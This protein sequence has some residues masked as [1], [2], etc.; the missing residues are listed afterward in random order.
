M[1]PTGAPTSTASCS[2]GRF[3]LTDFAD[4][5]PPYGQFRRTLSQHRGAARDQL[6]PSHR[7]PAPASYA[8]T[9]G[10]TF[11]PQLAAPRRRRDEAERAGPTSTAPALTTIYVYLVSLMRCPTALRIIHRS[12]PPTA[13]PPGPSVPQRRNSPVDR[14]PD[15][16]T[17]HPDM[18]LSASHAL[19]S[20]ISGVYSTPHR[21]SRFLLGGIPCFCS[22]RQTAE[23][24][25]ALRVLYVSVAGILMIPE[26]AC[27]LLPEIEITGAPQA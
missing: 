27:F 15:A 23:G 3:L 18:C 9:R 11:R 16:T 17:A 7:R 20:E 24:A 26:R 2:G 6:D 25:L 4:A 19:H 8:D 12:L 22:R 14:H 21:D 13:T 1:R 5:G 10:E